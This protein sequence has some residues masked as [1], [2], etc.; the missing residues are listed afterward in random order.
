MSTPSNENTE[1]QHILETRTLSGSLRCYGLKP[2]SFNSKGFWNVYFI[3]KLVECL[4]HFAHTTY[5]PTQG[6]DQYYHQFEDI[7]TCSDVKN[8]QKYKH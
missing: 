4:H 2:A 6:H 7:Q 3:F 8:Y 5:L 1:N